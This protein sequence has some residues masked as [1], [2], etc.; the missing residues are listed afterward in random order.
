MSNNK[1]I[2]LLYE[3]SRFMVSLESI[4]ISTYLKSNSFSLTVYFETFLISLRYLLVLGVEI[5]NYG[6]VFPWLLGSISKGRHFITVDAPAWSE[7]LEHLEGSWR[8]ISRCRNPS[9][10]WAFLSFYKLFLFAQKCIIQLIIAIG[11]QQPMTYI[12]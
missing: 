10:L 9:S 7:A 5:K 6:S 8:P 1:H 11:K 12:I 3:I 4:L 2:Y